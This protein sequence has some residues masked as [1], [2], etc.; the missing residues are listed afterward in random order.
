MPETTIR[1]PR[2]KRGQVNI[3]YNAAKRSEIIRNREE[4]RERYPNERLGESPLGRLIL[5]APP[6]WNGSTWMYP[7]EYGTFGT[8]E[9]YAAEED[10]E[11]RN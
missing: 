1:S 8:H 9:G 5:Y 7:Y 10:L 6:Y 4:L 11:Q 3:F 2:F